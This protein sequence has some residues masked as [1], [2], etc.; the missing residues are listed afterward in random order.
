MIKK[1]SYVLMAVAFLFCVACESSSTTTATDT[2][3]ETPDLSPDETPPVETPPDVT[4]PDV[5]PPDETPPEVTPPDETPPDVTP[6]DD[7]SV[8]PEPEDKTPKVSLSV[9]S[10][11]VPEGE[12]TKIKWDVR[13]ATL[14]YFDGKAV[15]LKGSL[16][17]TP[18]KLR[19]YHLT[20][21][22]GSKEV[23]KSI[24]VGVKKA[25]VAYNLE[26]KEELAESIDALSLAEDGHFL[27]LSSG[28]L[29]SGS[30]DKPFKALNPNNNV[31]EWATMAID[32]TNS[33]IMYAATD[34]R[35]YRSTN[36][37]DSWPDVIPVRRNNGD[38][39]INTL[40]VSP[41]NPHLVYVGVS[42]GAFVLD[43]SAKTLNLMTDLNKKE[44]TLFA[45]SESVTIAKTDSGLKMT[46]SNGASWGSYDAP[47]ML[48]EVLT[49]A[50]DT[51]SVWFGTTNGLFKQTA[52]VWE[53]FDIVDGAVFDL[54]VAND[55]ILVLSESGIYSNFDKGNWKKYSDETANW[56]LKAPDLLKAVFIGDD[57]YYGLKQDSQSN[58]QCPRV[59]PILVNPAIIN[60]VPT[61]SNIDWG[62]VR[63]VSQ[64]YQ[65]GILGK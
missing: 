26:A 64:A 22:N 18:K 21:I 56:I 57:A 29:Y 43:T 37:G 55:R 28:V 15:G 42:G 1:Y 60:T 31:S 5:T 23:K 10:T 53:H 20:A 49:I 32:P 35:V 25:V 17:V 63:S 11:C 45:S 58:N 51:E 39:T 33:Q 4:P 65:Q 40:Y 50:F 52:S 19:E 54:S 16:V 30:Y 3:D 2:P 13:D 6:P 7:D 62:V 27:A 47:E 46:T 44:V 24:Q 34:G 48:G 61:I 9:D 59:S 12:S 8:V 14:V 36:G 38:L 41:V